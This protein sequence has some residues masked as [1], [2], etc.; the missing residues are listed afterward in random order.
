M[1][2]GILIAGNESPLLAALAAEAAKRVE[3]FA[4][5]PIPNRLLQGE[6]SEAKGGRGDAQVR[7]DRQDHT[8][9]SALAAV[10][11]D[12][13]AGIPL[14]WNPGS[15]VSARTVILS[16]EN[17]LEHIDEALLVCAPPSVRRSVAELPARDIE[18]LVNDHIKGWFL[19]A[20]EL[21]SVFKTRRAGTLG[22]IFSDFPSGGGKDEK[23]DLLGSAAL[24]SFRAFSQS[25]LVSSFDEPYLSL[26]FSSSETGDEGPF[27]SFVFKTLDESSR[28]NNGK[29]YKFGK[30]NL[31]GR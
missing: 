17:R 2:R 5:A 6:Y 29:W 4:L 19:L 7:A 15:P 23:A 12:G 8:A 18:I 3:R 13:G 21:T 14:G 22:L 26:G 30:F 10:A 31:F 28:K 16:A 9:A 1:T 11:P 25:L 27:A 20:K 24:A